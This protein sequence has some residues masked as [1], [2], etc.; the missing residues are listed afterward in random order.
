MVKNRNVSEFQD[1]YK[2]K[3]NYLTEKEKEECELDYYAGLIVQ[4]YLDMKNDEA[5]KRIKEDI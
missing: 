2:G 4:V 3:L 1:I 5:K